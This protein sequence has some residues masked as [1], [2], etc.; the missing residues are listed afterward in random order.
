MP[1]AELDRHLHRPG[2]WADRLE[3]IAADP[4]RC[5]PGCRSLAAVKPRLSSGGHAAL[6]PPLTLE[7]PALYAA[8][9]R[10]NLLACERVTVECT[11]DYA[12]LTACWTASRAWTCRSAS[13]T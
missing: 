12:A 6:E 10:T 4:P 9:S 7:D 2:S 1:E 3:Q 8:A 11:G 13:P 5:L